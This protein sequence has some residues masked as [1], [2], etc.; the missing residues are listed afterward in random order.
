MF[1]AA[2]ARVAGIATALFGWRPEE[3]WN[4]TPSELNAI[5]TALAPLEAGADHALVAQLKEQFPDG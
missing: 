3:F 5:L 4:A 2:A 1:A